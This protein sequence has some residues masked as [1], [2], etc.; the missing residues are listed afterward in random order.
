MYGLDRIIPKADSTILIIDAGAIDLCLA[1]L[2]KLND[3]AHLMLAAN[4]GP[5][6]KLAKKLTYA[7]EYMNLDRERPQAQ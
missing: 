2:L 6:M 7:D 1:Q 3:D 4:I 5:K